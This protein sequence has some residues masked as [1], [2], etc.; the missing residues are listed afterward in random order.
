MGFLNPDNKSKL[1][2]NL[3][4]P[5]HQAPTPQ[6][7]SSGYL[8][9]GS[10]AALSMVLIGAAAWFA[11]EEEN[12]TLGL[13]Q[14]R[15]DDV[16]V[17]PPAAPLVTQEFAAV[18]PEIETPPETPVPFVDDLVAEVA[19]LTPEA[20][21]TQDLPAVESLASAPEVVP[22]DAPVVAPIEVPEEVAS[23][24]ETPVTPEIEEIAQVEA[25]EIIAPEEVEVARTCVDDIRDM[26]SNSTIYFSTNSAHLDANTLRMLRE[27]GVFV[28]ACPNAYVQVAGHSDSSGTDDTNLKLS[29][30]RADNVIYALSALGV[31]T[32]RFEPIGFG[33]R[34]PASE[35]DSTEPDYDR[36]I[37]FLVVERPE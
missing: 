29:W 24:D 4:L 33:A 9:I 27:L 14:N 26:A 8:L 37:E 7:V 1:D 23:L 32:K 16:V 12:G 11:L 5:G 2:A 21:T 25:P 18:S 10:L 3:G 28:E 22:V 15:L 31:D 36:R 17:T 13:A 34:A 19:D 20:E 6:N 30:R 35:G